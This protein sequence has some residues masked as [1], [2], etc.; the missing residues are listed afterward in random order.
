MDIENRSAKKDEMMRN[1]FDSLNS[2]RQYILSELDAARSELVELKSELDAIK[3]IYGNNE[4]RL[5]MKKVE[6]ARHG[7]DLIKSEV[8]ETKFELPKLGPD[9]Q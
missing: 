3:S 4:I 7:L 2:Q 8:V 6:E 1:L 5:L 9:G